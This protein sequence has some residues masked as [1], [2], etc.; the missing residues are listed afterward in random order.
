MPGASISAR[1]LLKRVLLVTLNMSYIFL[2]SSAASEDASSVEDTPL[3]KST[4]PKSRKQRR[5]ATQQLKLTRI[6]KLLA[7]RGVGSRSQVFEL[8]KARRITYAPHP[9]APHSERTRIKSPKEKVPGNSSLFLD[10]K[11]LP[12]PPPLLLVYHKPKHMLSSMGDAKQYQDQNRKHLGQVL[13]PKYVKAGMHP[14]GRLDFDTTGLILF[15]RD[16]QL[17][18]RLLHPRRGVQKEYVATVQ[19]LADEDELKQKLLD[20]VKTS[21]GVHTAELLEVAPSDGPA[22]DD[23]KDTDEMLTIDDEAD[24][25]SQSVVSGPFCDVRLVVQEGKHRMVR[26]MLAN[27]GHPVVELRRERHGEVELGDLKEGA[28]RDPT[29]EELEWAESLIR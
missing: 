24:E 15:S 4:K 1:S 20:G 2:R 19:G 22:D 9:D 14:V 25:G 18:Q 28:F 26:R 27:C 3:T 17:T 6:D 23:D 5:R 21:E 7:H 13:D 10:G 8:A 12:G 16:G 29:D 11:L